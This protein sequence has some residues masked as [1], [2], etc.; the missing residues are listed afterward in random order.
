[1]STCFAVCYTLLKI[2]TIAYNKVNHA[3]SAHE[4]HIVLHIL[5]IQVGVK[6]WLTHRRCDILFIVKEGHEIKKCLL[7]VSSPFHVRGPFVRNLLN[8]L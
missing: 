1:M 5:H 3:T 4:S 6:S 8:S 7:S 2:L